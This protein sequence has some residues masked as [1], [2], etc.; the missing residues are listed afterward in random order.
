MRRTY[1]FVTAMALLILALLIGPVF[2]QGWGRGYGRGGGMGMG[3]GMGRGMGMGPGMYGRQGGGFG[4]WWNKVNPQTPEQKA[5]VSKV[6]DLHNRIRTANQELYILRTQNASA[7]KI[8][9]KL[10]QINALRTEL[11]AVTTSNQGLL[12]QMGLP[13]GFGV[14]NGQGPGARLGCPF[15]AY[16]A[17]TVPNGNCA[18]C[19][20]PGANCATCPF[21]L[22]GTCPGCAYA[23]TGNTVNNANRAKNGTPLKGGGLGLRN[24]TG[25]N[26][27]CP[28]K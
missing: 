26:P 28:L 12:Q 20:N 15:A 10:N 9:Q 18:L 1:V 27:N 13:L 24:G 6:T 4:G 22:N 7:D 17:G 5:L 3:R 2:A 25:P 16:G 23:K 14:C 11:Q 21:Y 19:P 8:N